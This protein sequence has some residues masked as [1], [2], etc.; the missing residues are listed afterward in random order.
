MTEFLISLSGMPSPSFAAMNASG[1]PVDLDASAD[2]RES[3]ALTY[4]G[5]LVLHARAET[6][7]VRTSMMQY[8]RE[9]G[10]SAYWM[11]HSPTTPR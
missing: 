9:V 6:G 2:E 4:R 10:F 1:Y 3:R 8:S 5:D 11:L 7:T